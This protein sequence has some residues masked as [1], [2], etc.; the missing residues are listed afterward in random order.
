[1]GYQQIPFGNDK[2]GAGL[3]A[4]VYALSFAEDSG[5]GACRGWGLLCFGDAF[6][7]EGR[8]AVWG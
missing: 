7:E 8:C 1:M 3:K 4:A 2:T 6:Q 5:G